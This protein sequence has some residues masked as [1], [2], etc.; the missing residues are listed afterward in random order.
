MSSVKIRDRG[1]AAAYK[2]F[3]AGR[4]ESI[5][6]S[7]LTI[8]VAKLSGTKVPL[9]QPRRG[10]GCWC[11]VLRQKTTGIR[12]VYGRERRPYKG[13]GGPHER[14]GSPYKGAGGPKGI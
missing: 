9:G 14:A 13:A 2:P 10:L 3:E 7:C 8:Q 12:L 1:D 6:R 11:K 5:R 4:H